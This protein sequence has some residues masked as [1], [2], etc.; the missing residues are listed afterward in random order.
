MVEEF[1]LLVD[2]FFEGDR[3]ALSKLISVVERNSPESLKI[4]ADIS[5]RSKRTIFDSSFQ[6][7]GITGAP[8]VGKSTIISALLPNLRKRGFRVGVLLC[9][10]SSVKSQ[11]G[12]I[13]GDRIRIKTIEEDEGVFVRSAGTRGERGGISIN[14][15]DILNLFVFFGFDKIIVE[16][17]GTGQSETEISN[18]TDTLVL[19]IS[20][21]SG[22]EIQFMKA[23]ILE[24]ADIIVINKSDRPGADNIFND[25]KSSLEISKHIS[26]HNWD[27][28]VIKMVAKDGEGVSELIAAL[29]AHMEYIKNSELA[30]KRVKR[31]EYDFTNFVLRYVRSRVLSSEVFLKEVQLILQGKKDVYSSAYEVIK[32]I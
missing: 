6:V 23:G 31:A 3:F 20:P 9:D 30:K 12:A 19:A 1:G 16:T 8:G 15:S 25:I 29:S 26:P 11:G 32:S 24:L 27:I 7:I 10:P 17:A 5:K 21:E 22:D 28:P 18:F 13:L 14:T 4:L 2:R